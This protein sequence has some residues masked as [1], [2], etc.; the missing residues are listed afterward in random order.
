MK[1]KHTDN[2]NKINKTNVKMDSKNEKHVYNV[3]ARRYTIQLHWSYTAVLG[4]P[5]IGIVPSLNGHAPVRVSHGHTC[6]P[7]HQL[8]I[9]ISSWTVYQ[10][11][12]HSKLADMAA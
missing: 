8:A 11:T 3:N 5:G 7:P 9:N 6:I 12:Q 10:F 2:N 4:V 1:T